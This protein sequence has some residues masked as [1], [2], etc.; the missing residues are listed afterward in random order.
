MILV[1]VKYVRSGWCVV[2]AEKVVRGPYVYV[3]EARKKMREIVWE[4]PETPVQRVRRETK[5]L[6]HGES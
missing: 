3:E 4:Q 6:F 2:Q 1:D 5:E